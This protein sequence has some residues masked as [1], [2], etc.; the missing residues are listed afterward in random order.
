MDRIGNFK[1]PPN[2]IWGWRL[3]NDDTRL[4]HIKGD[5]M[6]VYKPLQ[7]ERHA[8]TPNR[9]TRVQIAIPTEKLGQYSP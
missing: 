5:V 8:T 4:L 2:K 6:D 9:W 7:V 3:D 1:A